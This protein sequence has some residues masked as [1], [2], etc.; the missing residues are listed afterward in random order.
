MGFNY[1]VPSHS[2]YPK[3]ISAAEDLDLILK[4][5]IQWIASAE[6]SQEIGMQREMEAGHSDCI[7]WALRTQQRT[8]KPS[9]PKTTFS[10]ESLIKYF[11]LW[12]VGFHSR[13]PSNHRHTWFKRAL[14][15]VC[16]N[17]PSDMWIPAMP[18]LPTSLL[19]ST[20]MSLRAE[21]LSGPVYFCSGILETSSVVKC[22]SRSFHLL[23]LELLSHSA[24]IISVFP[25]I[26]LLIHCFCNC[27][28]PMLY[29]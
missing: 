23:L 4:G 29:L 20:G 22:S 14:M 19:I 28:L 1:P 12:F 6:P 2:S 16:S 9:T 3:E 13:S 5:S 18:F 8:S 26:L 10:K 21:Y 25:K 27:T 11:C 17:R 24:R 15:G 7:S